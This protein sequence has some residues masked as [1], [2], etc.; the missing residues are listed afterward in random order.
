MSYS[1][2]FFRGQMEGSYSSAQV[3]MPY[4]IS[5]CQPKSVAD[6]GC[7]VGSWLQACR[8]CGIDDVTGVDGEYVHNQLL[9]IPP[10]SFV[11]A[12]LTQP[13]DLSRT[14][15]LVLSLE[16]A[17]HL[18]AAAARTFVE[19]LTRHGV[20]ILF[21]AAIPSQGGVH[22][23]NEQW[24]QYWS[25]L[26][27]DCGFVCVDC[28]RDVFWDT[29]T[30]E[31]WYRQNMFLY[32]AKD[33]LS[34]YPDLVVERARPRKLPVDLVHPDLL[35]RREVGIRTLLKQIP[36]ATSVSFRRLIG[37][38]FQSTQFSKKSR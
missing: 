7:G 24:A 28:L 32:V 20:V 18:P 5:L 9:M 10:E 19:T 25:S 16:V 17:E 4:V 33:C 1:S 26:F 15:D 38:M 12:D 34:K 22:H 8:E 35:S 13:I 2:T 37:R 6:F 11:S 21:S 36:R 31:W 30:V 27:G 14:F 3:V 29:K 23:T